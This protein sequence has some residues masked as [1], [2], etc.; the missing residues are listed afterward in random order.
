VAILLSWGLFV[1]WTTVGLA[2]LNAGRFRGGVRKLLL[3]PTVGFAAATVATYLVVQFEPSVAPV[4]R[5]VGA[6]MFLAALVVLWATRVPLRGAGAVLVRYRPF[7]AVLAATAVLTAWP[8]I[9]YG[10]DWV[11]NGNDDMANYC[12]GATGFRDHGYHRVP[13]PDDIVRPDDLTQPMWFLYR[14]ARTLTEKRCGAELALAL[15]SS[16][17]GLSP[18]S[19]FMPVI[20]AFNLALVSATAGLVLA[21][22]RRR[23][24]AAV[25]AALLALSSQTTYGVVQ[26]LIAQ[27]SG[28]ALFCTS[29]AMIGSPF[30]RFPLAVVFRRAAVCGVVFSGFVVYYPEAVPFLVGACVLSGLRDLWRRRSV[31]RLLW[32]AGGAIVIMT[33]L[34]PVYLYGTLTF[35]LW[36]ATQAVGSEAHTLEIFPYFMTPRG[37]ALVFGLLPAAGDLGEPLHTAALVFGFAFLAAAVAIAWREFRRDGRPFAAV[38][39]LMAAVGGMLYLEDAAFGLFKLAMFVQPFLW[40]TVSV[41]LAARRGRWAVALATGCVAVTAAMNAGTQY[42]YVSRSTGRDNRVDLPAMTEQHVMSDFHARVVPR[43]EAE[44]PTRVLLATENNVLYKL[45]AAEMRQPTSLNTMVLFAWMLEADKPGTRWAELNAP[46]LQAEAARAADGAAET[47]VIDPDTGA[48]RHRLMHTPVDWR[49]AP[50]DNVWVLTGGGKVS[51]FNRYHYP[52]ADRALVCEPLSAVHNLALFRDADGARQ[53]FLGMDRIEDV[54]LHRLESDPHFAGRT[55]AGVGRVVVVDVLNPTPRVRVLLNYTGSYRPDPNHRGVGPAEVVGTRRV[56]VG[57][58]GDGSARLVSPPVEPQ[59]AGPS[60]LLEIDF[61]TD[62]IRAP[63]KL[64]GVEA[65]WGTSL[66]RDRRVLTGELRDL[67]VISEAEYAAFRPPEKLV[68]FPEDL[69]HPHIEYSGVYEDGWVNKAFKVR[70]TQPAAGGELAFRGQIPIAPGTE[71]FRTELSVLIDGRPAHSRTL[72]PGDFEVRVPA[73]A[74][75]GPRWVECRFSDSFALPGG[76]ERAVAARVTGIGFEPKGETRSRPP[77]A[78]AIFPADLNRPGVEPAGIDADG[79]VG[80]AG[81]ARLWFAGPGRA[82]VVRTHVP[83]IDPN[84]RPELTVFLDGAEVARRTL[85]PGDAEVRV[86]VPPGPAAARRVECRFSGTQR[87][88]A[89]D[90]RTVAA[91]LLGVGFE[92]DR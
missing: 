76:D 71:G 74:G 75:T 5:P 6:A 64:T 55:M 22:T 11:A 9:G 61:N 20:V 51:V 28:L 27:A 69:A 91:R 30:R 63:N 31:N 58:L 53:L 92:P 80:A 8:M 78:V 18:Q 72:G 68:R 2:V 7:A 40:A 90:T 88:P 54:A 52:E 16:W 60:N 36:Q 50:G 4:A 42:T 89:P 39:L 25:A 32:H 45:L 73:G 29:L 57:A 49:G 67:S 41:W 10:F 85:A 82:L 44:R 26:Q 47:W 62:A 3:A 59:H 17:T 77:E 81:G 87:L 23:R 19:V 79:W 65:A 38:V 1:Y 48:R 43:L 21:A 24:P 35:L 56:A 86:P 46:A 14:D 13:T 83:L 66:P 37:P 34:V 15:T 84:F 33:A 70:L 12:L